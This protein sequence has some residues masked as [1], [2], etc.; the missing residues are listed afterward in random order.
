MTPGVTKERR[1]HV[2]SSYQGA[3]PQPGFAWHDGSIGPVCRALQLSDYAD[4]GFTSR[5]LR[6][7]DASV[8]D[9]Y[10]R[11]AAYFGVD[12]SA[13]VNVRQVHG[14][15]VL[16]PT[17]GQLPPAGAEADAIVTTQP[18][19]LLTVRVA[20]C[21][22]VLLADRLGRAVAV[23]HA[24]WR[25]TAAGVA[26][27]TV[28][29]LRACGVD[30]GDLVAAI[31]PSIGPCCYEVREDVRTAMR[32]G[33]ALADDWFAEAGD[34]RWRLNLWQA[35]RAQLLGAGLAV[36]NVHVAEICTADNLGVC[37]SHRREGPDTGRMVAAIRKR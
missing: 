4:H 3:A 17:G 28:G 33:Q 6:F 30:P 22:P 26:T 12:P 35:N 37:Y 15:E 16:V 7:R 23:V 14:R 21:V 8:P 20:D 18:G 34:G 1:K 32:Q 5:Q 2:N 24:G 11:L 27:A 36:D 9:D 10:R 19:L 25:G 13:V 31:G 29:A